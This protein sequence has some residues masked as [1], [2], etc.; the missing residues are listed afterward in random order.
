[1]EVW[2]SYKLQECTD[3]VTDLMEGGEALWRKMDEDVFVVCLY[4]AVKT[5]WNTGPTRESCE[6]R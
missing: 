1:M 5:V 6:N 2:T 3:G 4:E